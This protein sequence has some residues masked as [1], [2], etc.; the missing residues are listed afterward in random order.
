MEN[1]KSTENK[2]INSSPLP[3]KNKQEVKTFSFPNAM[4]LIQ[5]GKKITRLAWD[6]KDYGIKKD[7]FLM[8]YKA[9]NNKYHQ[10]IVSDGD[11][12]A[13]DWVIVL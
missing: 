3:Q 2:I 12:D 4:Q 11:I 8:L 1:K 10:W 13:N 6:T 9:E 7:G 5:E